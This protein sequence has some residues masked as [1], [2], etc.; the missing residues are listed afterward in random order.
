MMR[1]QILVL[2][3]VAIAA[4][5]AIVRAQSDPKGKTENA[6]AKTKVYKFRSMDYPGYNLS[7]VMAYEGGIAVGV[8]S[9]GDGTEIGFAYRGT[10]Y[11]VIS[12]P[13]SI[14]SRAN[15]VN[16]SGH[17]AGE[18]ADDK[19]ILHAFLYDGKTYTTIDPPDAAAAEA[20]GINESGAIVGAY[21]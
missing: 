8:T 3:I 18:Y 21:C 14:D 1:S 17:I 2:A 20:A 16:A 15:A 10:T 9:H 6:P 4:G 19:D 13:G 5:S 7:T 11:S 12:Y